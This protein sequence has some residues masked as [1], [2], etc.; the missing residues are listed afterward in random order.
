MT[1]D[2]IDA[3]IIDL[4]G[5]GELQIEIEYKNTKNEFKECIFRIPQICLLHDIPSAGILH[6]NDHTI[7]QLTVTDVT[8][9]NIYLP[10]RCQKLIEVRLLDAVGGDDITE[11]FLQ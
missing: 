1:Q 10:D 3:G 2:M 6:M 5:S 11:M 9:F 4:G 8:T 7:L